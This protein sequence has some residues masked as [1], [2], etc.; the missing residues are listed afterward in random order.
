[1]I[2]SAVACTPTP[3]EVL[4][5]TV[6][7][8]DAEAS[9]DAQIPATCG[10][11]MLDPGEECE[12]GND[13]QLD[14]CLVD[15]RYGPTGFITGMPFTTS[16]FGGSGSDVPDACPPGELLVALRGVTSAEGW[17]VRLQGFCGQ[18]QLVLREDGGYLVEIADGSEL[19]VYGNGAGSDGIARCPENQVAVGFGGRYGSRVDQLLLRC[20]PIYVFDGELG[21][22]QSLGDPGDTTPIGGEGGGPIPE[23]P[24]GE[25]FV[26]TGVRLRVD[27]TVVA[28][29]L[30]CAPLVLQTGP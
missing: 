24:C 27:Q 21:W 12:D 4:D 15:C 18:P 14:G 28:F 19:S 13:D 20:A 23:T 7:N 26:A 17:L 11:G 2:A 16:L 10:N 9:D 22:E 25:G 29:G 5:P 6:G 3:D 1:M 8:D 30:E